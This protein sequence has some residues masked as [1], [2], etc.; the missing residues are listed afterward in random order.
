MTDKK[1]FQIVNFI[2]FFLIAVFLFNYYSIIPTTQSVLTSLD[3]KS[4]INTE[5]YCRLFSVLWSVWFFGS[6]GILIYGSAKMKY[7]LSLSPILP[8]ALAILL[9]VTISYIPLLKAVKTGKNYQ[10]LVMAII[11]MF[12]VF[13][14]LGFLQLKKK[15]NTNV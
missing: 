13:L 15:V 8:L 11:A 7:L 14:V 4:G 10:D 12:P 6:N 2:S 1:Q 5:L 3:S 9:T